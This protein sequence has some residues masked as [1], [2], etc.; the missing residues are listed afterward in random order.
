[1]SPVSIVPLCVAAGAIIEI[2]DEADRRPLSTWGP[3]SSCQ[4]SFLSSS[5]IVGVPLRTLTIGGGVC[6]YLHICGICYPG[7]AFFRWNDVMDNFV[8]YCPVY[9]VIGANH[10]FLHTLSESVPGHSVSMRIL[11]GDVSPRIRCRSTS[12]VLRLYFVIFSFCPRGSMYAVSVARI[13]RYSKCLG[14]R[15][16]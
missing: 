10:N 13:R 14:I 12:Y 6:P 3:F 9:P 7:Q 1:M 16:R 15:V 2:E 11:V 5:S 4:Q 8:P